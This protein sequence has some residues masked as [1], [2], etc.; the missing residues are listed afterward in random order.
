MISAQH[1]ARRRRRQKLCWN[2][3]LYKQNAINLSIPT[4]RAIFQTFCSNMPSLRTKRVEMNQ[5]G[6]EKELKISKSV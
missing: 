2:R 1:L 4:F 3:V 6:T 5:I